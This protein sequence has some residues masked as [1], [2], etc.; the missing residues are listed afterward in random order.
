MKFNQELMGLSGDLMSTRVCAILM[1]ELKSGVY[2]DVE[3]LPA[4]MDLAEQFGVSR[5]VIRD[6]LS[7]LESAGFVQRVRGIGTVI[8]RN[9]VEINNRLDLKL[10]YNEMIHTAG[11]QAVT[12]NIILR[13]ERSEASIS[14]KL[15]ID[16]GAPLIVCQKRILANEKPA[17]YSIDYLPLSLFEHINYMA[18]DWSL[19]IFDLL[20]RYCGLTVLN[21][22]S[23]VS[24]VNADSY[25][26][27]RLNIPEHTALLSLE[28]ISFCKL[29]RPVM[30]SLAF[31]TDLFNFTLLRKKF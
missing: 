10:E 21:S 24:A 12:D 16:Q 31:Y 25:I 19:P 1:R 7:I 2:Q 13:E 26:S 23:N 30:Y 8:N 28:E 6:A 11:Y 4:E 29:N 27:S 3:R 15:H 5:T 18:L 22:I 14:E 17:I 9:I 20:E